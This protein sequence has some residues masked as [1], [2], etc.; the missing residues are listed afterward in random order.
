MLKIYLAPKVRALGQAGF[1]I[2]M[3]A[4]IIEFKPARGT[5]FF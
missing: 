3:Q 5:G 2:G 1:D 4:Q